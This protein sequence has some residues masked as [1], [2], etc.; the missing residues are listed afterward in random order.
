[1]SDIIIRSA[2]RADVSVILDFIKSSFVV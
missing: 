2:M 1:M